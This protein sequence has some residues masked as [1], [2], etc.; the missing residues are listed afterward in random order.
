L[1]S[2]VI[3]GVNQFNSEEEGATILRNVV[4]LSPKDRASY[5]GRF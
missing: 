2:T 5:L 3:V 4:N 1:E